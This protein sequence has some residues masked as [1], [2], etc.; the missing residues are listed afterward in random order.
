[1]DFISFIVYNYLL[2]FLGNLTAL[3]IT[4]ELHLKD[5]K[6]TCQNVQKVRSI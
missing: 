4:I 3:K 6:R 1:M 2:L 5:E